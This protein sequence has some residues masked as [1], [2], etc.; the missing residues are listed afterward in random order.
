MPNTEP[1]AENGIPLPV[2]PSHRL[3][4][5]DRLT[6]GAN[7]ELDDERF[8]YAGRVLRLRVGD[9]VVLFDG[10]GGEFTAVIT[11]VSRRAI[12]LDV[13][14]H[15]ERDTESP[16]EINLVQGVSRGERMDLVVQKATE[17]GVQRITPVLTERS[18]VRLPG[19]KS[20]RRREHWEKVAQSACEQCGRNVVPVIDEPQPFASWLA[21]SGR[22]GLQKAVLR[23]GAEQTLAGLP[24]SKRWQLLIGP[25]GGL[26][27]AELE[28]SI[29]AG[30]VPCALGPR[31]LRTETAAIAALV[32]L[33]ERFGDLG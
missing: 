18:V 19:D 13:G 4:V 17:L 23:P 31:V 21:S 24:A 16:L 28:R 7:L 25:E 33:Q 11:A 29:E 14:P 5:P 22:S 32:V 1:D 6:A 8:R 3:Y 9:E 27:E 10:T 30:F 2:L 26:A 12:V 20:E 15:R